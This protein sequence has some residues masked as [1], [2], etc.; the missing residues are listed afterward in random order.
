MAWWI[1]VGEWSNFENMK[2]N[3]EKQILSIMLETNVIDNQTF[4]LPFEIVR[5]KTLKIMQV[6]YDVYILT[7]VFLIIDMHICII[8]YY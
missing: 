2:I 8:P 4:R 1:I 7:Y 3:D 5:F 6:R